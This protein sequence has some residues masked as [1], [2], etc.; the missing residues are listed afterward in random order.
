VQGYAVQHEV[1]RDKE[2]SVPRSIRL[3]LLSSGVAIAALLAGPIAGAQA[4]DST[5]IATL[6]QW[7]PRIVNDE[8]A[9]A[10]G[11]TSYT[12]HRVKPLVKALHREVAD[13][14]TLRH[15]L[16]GESA[17]SAKGR[18]AKGD[19]VKGLGLIAK[20]YGTLSKDVKA[21]RGNGVPAAQVQ[22]AIK[23]DKTGRADLQRG[24]KL[25]GG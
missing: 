14:Q 17:S 13:L 21:S 18:K 22:A 3:Y 23:T 8:N 7:G 25:L 16:R 15:Q 4:S 20:A 1:H 12:H 6:N 19:I 11:L 9:V 2:D 5:I 24:I 10:K